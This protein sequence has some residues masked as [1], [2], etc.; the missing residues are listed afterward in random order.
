[1]ILLLFTNHARA[2][3]L[4]FLAGWM[5]AVT[6]AMAVLIQVISTQ[7]VGGTD[8]PSSLG[9]GVTL[10]LG[11]LL[12]GRAI[13]QWHKRPT[14]GEPAEMPSWIARLD[15][16]NPL[17]AAGLAV[18]LAVLNPKNLL[19][20]AGGAVILLLIGVVLIGKGIKGLSQL[21]TLKIKPAVGV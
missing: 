9:A 21:G 13:M 10:A 20:I 14:P 3:S 5:V 2:N 18:A 12:F 17:G 1:V 11:A 4:A 8:D 19:L 15:A 16:M 6:A 7:D